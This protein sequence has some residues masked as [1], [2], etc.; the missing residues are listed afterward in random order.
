[1]HFIGDIHM[2]SYEYFKVV[3]SVNDKTVQVGDFGV[4]FGS[5]DKNWTET[6]GA[7][8]LDVNARFIRGNH[9]NPAACKTMKSWIPDGTIENDIMYVGGALSIDAYRRQED[10]DWWEDEELSYDELSKMIDIY[11]K[12]K[13]RVMIAHECPESAAMEVFSFYKNEMPSRTRQAFQ[14]MLEL[15][16]PEAW[17]FGHWHIDIDTVINGTRFI[18]LNELSTIEFDEKTFEFGDIKPFT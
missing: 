14:S 2:K 13:P 17:V 3:A 10:W 8:M 11:E 1:M 18:C 5:W 6:L 12:A 4:G 9:D 16:Q 7:E 15:H